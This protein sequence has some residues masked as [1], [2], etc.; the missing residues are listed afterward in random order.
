[1]AFTF[2]SDDQS[3][4]LIDVL[5]QV[6][7]GSTDDPH[8]PGDKRNHCPGCGRLVDLRWDGQWCKQHCAALAA[9]RMLQVT[10]NQPVLYCRVCGTQGCLRQ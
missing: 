4:L 10:A 9:S 2:S 8:T 6:R 3:D 5:N 1:M 7:S